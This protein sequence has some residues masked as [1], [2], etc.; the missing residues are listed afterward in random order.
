MLDGLQL[1]ASQATTKTD[2]LKCTLLGFL[3]LTQ[4]YMC[5]IQF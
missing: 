5:G 4:N 3:L 1:H 2:V